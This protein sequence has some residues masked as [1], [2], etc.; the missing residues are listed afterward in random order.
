MGKAHQ[1]AN[2][3]VVLQSVA[4]EGIQALQALGLPIGLLFIE[5]GGTGLTHLMGDGLL[6][7]QP[8]MTLLIV[9]KHIDQ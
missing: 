5:I 7:G 8:G 1:Q 2:A 4:P 3:V 6:P 9:V